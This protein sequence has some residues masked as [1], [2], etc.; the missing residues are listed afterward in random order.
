MAAVV[1]KNTVGST[2]G[3]TLGSRDWLRVSPPERAADAMAG[4]LRD[5]LVRVEPVWRCG[6]DPYDRH[7]CR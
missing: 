7:G 2:L 1:A 3:K 5:S 6:G 4:R